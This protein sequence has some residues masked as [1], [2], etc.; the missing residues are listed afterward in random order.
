[1]AATKTAVQ[2]LASTSNAVGGT[3]AGAWLDVSTAY[4]LTIIGS[5]TNPS[6]APSAGV[7]QRVQVADD[8]TGT[9]ASDYA[10]EVAPTTASASGYFN[11]VVLPP[12]AMF[13]RVFYDSNTGQPVTVA[14]RG[15]KLTGV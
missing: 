11:P 8:A 1:M 5:Y 13:A 7:R 12:E 2:A 9:N 4:G 14:A 15:W 6:T 3:T 10:F